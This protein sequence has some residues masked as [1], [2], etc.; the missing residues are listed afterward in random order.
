MKRAIHA[1]R[2]MLALALAWAANGCFQLEYDIVLRDGDDGATITERFGLTRELLELETGAPAE[3]KLERHLTREAVLERMKV[4]GAGI[5][6]KEHKRIENPDGSLES[7]AVFEIPDVT[8]LRL[9]NPL[10]GNSRPVPSMKLTFSP[11]QER[12]WGT[13]TGNRVRI[14]LVLDGRGNAPAAPPGATP[15]DV[16]YYREL[17]PAY[18]DMMRGLSVAVRLTVPTDAQG[19]K[20]VHPIFVLSDRNTDRGGAPFL[21]NEEAMVAMLRV[22][23]FSGAIYGHANAFGTDP[24]VPVLR[25]RNLIVIR[26]TTRMSEKWSKTYAKP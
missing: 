8:A 4:M 22:A 7:R 11:Y 20:E 13:V 18:A 15:F 17:A 21:Q 9:P 3:Q 26:P 19:G 25:R 6:L 1:L 16:Q 5:V 12:M 2:T 23:P 24:N 14:H 10:V